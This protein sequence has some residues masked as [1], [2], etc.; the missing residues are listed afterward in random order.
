[1]KVERGPDFLLSLL[2]VALLQSGPAHPATSEIHLTASDQMLADYFRAETAKLRERCLT[3]IRIL[4]DWTSR[5]EKYRRQ[6]LEM[7]DRKSVV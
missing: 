4:D 6:L 2:V 1:M 3:D 7:L 5:R